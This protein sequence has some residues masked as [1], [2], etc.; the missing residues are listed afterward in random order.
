MGGLNGWLDIQQ[1]IHAAAAVIRR[2]LPMALSIDNFLHTHQATSTVVALGKLAI[3]MTMLREERSSALLGGS[4]YASYGNARPTLSL[5]SEKVEASW[6]S[7]FVRTL[8]AG[9][10]AN[11]VREAF[12]NVSFVI[13]NYD[14]CLEAALHVAVQQ[15][16]DVDDGAAAEALDGVLFLHP[17]GSLGDLPWQVGASKAA[18]PFGGGDGLDLWLIANGIRTFTESVDS[19]E[20]QHIKS[21]VAE[22]EQLVFLGFGFLEQNVELLRSFPERVTTRNA[23]S[24]AYKM[25][26][27]DQLIMRRVIE[28]FVQRGDET[29]LDDGGCRE[30]FDHNR[31]RFA[32]S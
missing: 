10:V 24:T 5:D 17:Y 19:A 25:Q 22:A 29:I 3:V 30:L 8:F 28:H 9:A 4:W 27:D 26:N 32:Y 13:F 23:L 12:E 6:Y 7:P 11:N 1:E 15:Y 18:V 2:G 21:V 20:G 16:F 31:L 14:R